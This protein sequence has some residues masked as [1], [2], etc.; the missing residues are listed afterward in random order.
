MNIHCILLVLSSLYLLWAGHIF[1]YENYD[2]EVYWRIY[3]QHDGT[4]VLLETPLLQRN[5]GYSDRQILVLLI[6]IC[7]VCEGHSVQ[8]VQEHQGNIA[9]EI[10]NA[11]ANIF[12]KTSKTYSDGWS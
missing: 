7:E 1:L 10:H 3:I 9:K 5:R 4:I 12:L 2:S 11:N 8:T 6:F